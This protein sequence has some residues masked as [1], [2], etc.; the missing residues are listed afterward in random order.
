[1][2]EL[3]C[4]ASRAAE[5]LVAA[6]PGAP[7]SRPASPLQPPVASAQAAAPAAEVPPPVA[8]ERVVQPAW[9]TVVMCTSD[10]QGAGLSSAASDATGT[11]QPAV[12]L[13]LHGNR[14]SSQRVKLPSQAG[15]FERGQE[16]VFR[17]VVE[18]LICREMGVLACE[19]AFWSKLPLAVTCTAC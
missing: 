17:Q 10:E 7:K 5:P 18:V 14:S 15:D 1:M 6:P 19:E 9:Y 16:D 4:T 13:V 8:A 11:A 3:R 2:R 12:F